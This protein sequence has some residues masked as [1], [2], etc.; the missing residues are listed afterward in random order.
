MSS[1]CVGRSNRD[2]YVKTHFH[3]IAGRYCGFAYRSDAGYRERGRRSPPWRRFSGRP[4][5]S[6]RAWRIHSEQHKSNRLKPEQHQLERRPQF[7]Q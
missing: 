2:A 7:A 1:F 4:K 6:E 5:F 3:D